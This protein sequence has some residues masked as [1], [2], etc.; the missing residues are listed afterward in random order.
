MTLL[1][2]ALHFERKKNPREDAIPQPDFI[3][4][5]A[6]LLLWNLAADMQQMD[7]QPC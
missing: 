7:R 5:S 1:E 2:E 3:T 6:P 4:K